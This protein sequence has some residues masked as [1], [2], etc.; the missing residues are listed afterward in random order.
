MTTKETARLN[1]EGCVLTG[2]D[3]FRTVISHTGCAT[4]SALLGVGVS[5]LLG[6]L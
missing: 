6:V 3:H 1:W 5:G 2:Y 4:R